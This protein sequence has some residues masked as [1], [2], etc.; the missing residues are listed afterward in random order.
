MLPN[1]T[2]AVELSFMLPIFDLEFQGKQQTIYLSGHIDRVVHFGDEVFVCDYKTSK[3]SLD[4]DWIKQFQPSN[5]FL[6]YYTAAQIR[7]SQP[8]SVFTA[9]PSG[10]VVD[11]V[12]LGVNFNRYS[13]FPLRY[14][15]SDADQFLQDFEALVRIKALG[16]AQMA[17]WPGESDNECHAYRGCEF[18][19]AC[20]RSPKEWDYQLKQNFVKGVWDPRKPR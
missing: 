18:L 7:A 13:R 9:P 6:L 5:Q 20:T 3:Y 15:Q 1:G 17:H 4:K 16:A 12:Q 10:V 14:T 8:N 19:C 11:G 2:P